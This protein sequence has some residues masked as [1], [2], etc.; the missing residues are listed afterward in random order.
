VKSCKGRT[1]CERAEGESTFR[2]VAVTVREW[3]V[4]LNSLNADT[5]HSTVGM[6]QGR[7]GYGPNAEQPQPRN[8]FLACQ[9]NLDLLDTRNRMRHQRPETLMHA[10]IRQEGL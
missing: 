9:R 10:S 8:K 5:S 1:R 2:L 3:A 6:R 7:N 4:H